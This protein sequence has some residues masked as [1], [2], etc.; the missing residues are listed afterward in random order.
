MRQTSV[1]HKALSIVTTNLEM[2]TEKVDDRLDE[3]RWIQMNWSRTNEHR[4]AFIHGK[5]DR[6]E[7]A[8]SLTVTSW[9]LYNF[10]WIF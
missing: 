7:R 5:L 3:H 8:G 1:E 2:K 9:V 4:W 6:C 10:L